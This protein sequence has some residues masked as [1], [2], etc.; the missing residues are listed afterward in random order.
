[1]W[2]KS[3]IFQFGTLKRPLDNKPY[4]LAQNTWGSAS[5]ETIPHETIHSLNRWHF[6]T[7]SVSLARCFYSPTKNTQLFARSNTSNTTT[8]KLSSLT[9]RTYTTD[10]ADFPTL[11]GTPPPVFSFIFPTEK[12][13]TITF[14]GFQLLYHN[15][16]KSLS[17]LLRGLG[18]LMA[19]CLNFTKK[20]SGGYWGYSRFLGDSRHL[21]RRYNDITTKGTGIINF[22]GKKVFLLLW[23]F[24]TEALIFF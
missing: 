15:N 1:M 19:Y 2:K 3:I 8:I 4:P 22:Q 13:K 7:T 12:H 5:H 10:L 16:K 24:L 9:Y 18:T 11:I 23:S 17:L 20:W 6:T 14:R 21:Q